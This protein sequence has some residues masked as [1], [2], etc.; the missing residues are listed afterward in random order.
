MTN[1][2]DKKGD[3]PRGLYRNANNS[4][5]VKMQVW[6]MQK[7]KSVSLGCGVYPNKG[8]AI[9]AKE[10]VSDIL[11]PTIATA[12][13]VRITAIKEAINEYRLSIGLKQLRQ[14]YTK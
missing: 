14:T 12:K 10:I 1:Y 9:G 6:S 3:L 7:N 4:V 13:T 2:K 5:T 11:G 8:M